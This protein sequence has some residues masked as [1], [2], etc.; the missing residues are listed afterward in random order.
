MPTADDATLGQLEKTPEEGR[1]K[2]RK[3]KRRQSK[4]V[5][6]KEAQATEAPAVPSAPVPSET[7]ETEAADAP[8]TTEVPASQETSEE[9]GVNFLKDI[10]KRCHLDERLLELLA[11]MPLLLRSRFGIHFK[12][13]VLTPKTRVVKCRLPAIYC[14][15]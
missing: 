3:R 5:Q 15:S 13:W 8:E 9:K 14:G 12:Q 1:V 10:L 6:P 7:Q 4:G 2:R 11:R